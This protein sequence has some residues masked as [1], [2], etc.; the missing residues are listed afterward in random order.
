MFRR[1]R[2][3]YGSLLRSWFGGRR[4]HL[5]HFGSRLTISATPTDRR[6]IVGGSSTLSFQ[7]TRITLFGRT[8]ILDILVGI[9]RSCRDRVYASTKVWLFCNRLVISVCFSVRLFLYL[10]LHLFCCTRILLQYT[11][12]INKLSNHQVDIEFVT[13]WLIICSYAC[14]R[15]IQIS[16]C[17]K[18]LLHST[19]VRQLVKCCGYAH[20]RFGPR[21]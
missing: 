19:S 5:S 11:N 12:S 6:S 18:R 8:V 20:N 17:G 10:S 3:W 13:S 7:R 9:L 15:R 16:S 21:K 14:F 4:Y 1:R 2:K